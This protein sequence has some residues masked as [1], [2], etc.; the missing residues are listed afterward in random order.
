M[1]KV[2]DEMSSDQKETKA[3]ERVGQFTDG[4]AAIE[5]ALNNHA[6][7]IKE[8][9]D[10]IEEDLI[11]ALDQLRDELRTHRVTLAQLPGKNQPMISNPVPTQPPVDLNRIFYGDK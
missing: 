6:K 8:L 1:E 2:E 9:N 7:N 4:F 11:G 5:V 3:D 10:L